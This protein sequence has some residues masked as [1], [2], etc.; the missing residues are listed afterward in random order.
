MADELEQG[1]KP[2]FWPEKIAAQQYA[3]EHIPLCGYT[4]P[5]REGE[6]S[7]SVWDRVTDSRIILHVARA[8]GDAPPGFQAQNAVPVRGLYVFPQKGAGR[9]AESPMVGRKKS[10]KKKEN[11][12]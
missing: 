5:R 2:P 10:H 3:F 12:R 7:Y 11:E 8:P 6:H 1:I 4:V 9:A